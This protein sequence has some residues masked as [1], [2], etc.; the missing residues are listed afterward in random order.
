MKPNTFLFLAIAVIAMSVPVLSQQ[1][2]TSKPSFEV[3]TVKRNLTGEQISSSSAQ[4]RSGRYVATAAT[5][6]RLMQTAYQLRDFQLIGGPAWMSSDRWNIEA[7][8]EEGSLPQP[9][10][11]LMLQSL[12]EERFQLKLRRETREL[13]TYDLLVARGGH[14]LKLS[15][16]QSI[17][18][19]PQRGA[20]PLPPP[21]PP[22]RG[23]PLPRGTTFGG[24]GFLRATA[25]PLSNLI[26]NLSDQ[27]G[28]TIV[29][30]TGLTGLYDITLEWTPDLGQRN[31]ILGGPDAPPPAAE[32]S[33][34]SI[35]TAL[36]EQLGLR[37]ESSRG[38]VEVL[39]IE[40]AEK[41]TEN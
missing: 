41:P 16:D 17:P 36:Q 32:L 34:P 10:L 33:G 15:E 31:P 9:D 6:R 25:Q 21:A 20:A 27:V 14:K 29:D 13:P 35:F 8:A 28:R 11:S 5:L 24:R 19:P 7:K 18:G 40:A 2:A 37:L 1:P 4:A 23:A 39:V 38:P 30:K 3:A 22:Q 26:R 12:L